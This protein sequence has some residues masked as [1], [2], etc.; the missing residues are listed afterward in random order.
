M[1]P[2]PPT[3]N[4]LPNGRPPSSNHLSKRERLRQ[5]LGLHSRRK[6]TV[7]PAGLAALRERE[8]ARD[9]CPTLVGRTGGRLASPWLRRPRCCRCCLKRPLQERRPVS[10][11]FRAHGNRPESTKLMRGIRR[12]NTRARKDLPCSTPTDRSSFFP[13]TFAFA[14]LSGSN[15]ER[16]PARPPRL[17]VPP[18]SALGHN[19]SRSEHRRRTSR[20]DRAGVLAGLFLFD[21]ARRA[22]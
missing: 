12:N 15:P 7:K 1:T 10:E 3:R 19:L 14:R 20:A 2:L 5:M 21:H 4:L 17:P 6:S 13:R 9:G 18:S 8:R 16:A 22:K 11:P